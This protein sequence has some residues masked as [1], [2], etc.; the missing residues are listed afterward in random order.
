MPRLALKPDSSF[1][2]KIALGAVG[3]RSVA[4]DLA[5]RG[6][7][8][9]ELERGSTDT[10]LWKEVKRKRVRIPDLVCCEC[11]LRVESRAKT[12]IDLAMSHSPTDSER[13]WDFG[14][15]DA[16]VVAF[17]ICPAVGEK[18]WSAGK[19]G[20]NNVSYWHERNW[21]QWQSGGHINYFL[22]RGFRATPHARTVTKG[23]TEGSETSVVWLAVFCSRD[24]VVEAVEGSQITIR[25]NSD[26]HRYT[27]KAPAN[28]PTLVRVGETVSVNQAI[29]SV[30]APVAPRDL[31]CPRQLPKDHIPQ[32]L[33]SRE[34]TQ[35]FTGV[36]LARL[37]QDWSFI[38]QVRELERDR[39]EDVYIRLE[40]ASYLVAA[41]A[42]SAIKMFEPYLTNTEPQT[43][44]ETVIALGETGTPAAIEFLSEILDTGARPYFI[45]SAAAWCLGRSGIPE[46]CGR[47]VKAFA[48]VDR[49]IREE[50]LEGIV[51]VGGPA[52]PYLL[53]GIEEAGSDIAAGCAEAIRQQQ[54]AL[55]QNTLGT[56]TDKLLKDSPA[57]WAVWLAGHLRRD[58]VAGAVSGLQ[59]KAPELHY[60][61]S[62]L[63]S[64]VESWI[65]RRWELRPDSTFPEAESDHGA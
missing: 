50:A 64:F 9:A 5:A 54:N 15:V 17:P 41:G 26:G 21:V 10:K 13:A 28:V 49:N 58:L 18:L 35:R 3:T 7:R 34:R 25:R 23:V 32:L 30:V 53:S 24:G 39:E 61:I 11:G 33:M 27:W 16:D 65:S 40:A 42:V 46:A 20:A 52:L 43:Q 63:W 55:D 47:L 36:K 48:D 6:H 31:E 8:I 14:M 51:A 59:D 19:L 38:E 4:A 60:A 2:R 29:A 37:R 12:K 44:L 22:A 56:L 57:P 45:R 62:L 1:F